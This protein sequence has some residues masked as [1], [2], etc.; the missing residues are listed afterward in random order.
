M[1]SF[2][3]IQRKNPR[4]PPI[5]DFVLNGHFQLKI[6]NQINPWNSRGNL[7]RGIDWAYQNLKKWPLG[8][9]SDDFMLTKLP[10]FIITDW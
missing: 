10:T 2:I 3:R 6:K 8:G 5:Y 1:A 9:Q 4:V 7:I